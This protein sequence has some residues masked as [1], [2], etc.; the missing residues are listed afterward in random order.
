MLSPRHLDPA[1]SSGAR[2]QEAVSPDRTGVRGPARRRRRRLLR[3]RRERRANASARSAESKS[4]ARPPGDHGWRLAGRTQALLERLDALSPEE[5]EAFFSRQIAISPAPDPAAL[6]LVGARAESGWRS[7]RLAPRLRTK[8]APCF[9]RWPGSP[10]ST[11]PSSPAGRAA[12]ARP[13]DPA[14]PAARPASRRSR[15]SSWRR[16]RNAAD[17]VGGDVFDAIELSPSTPGPDARR[18]LGARSSRGA[19]SARRRRGPADGRRPAPED[20]C[21]HRAAQPDPLH[22]DAGLAFR[23]ARLRRA[24][25]FGDL[26][27]R[28]RRPSGAASADPARSGARGL[29]AFGPGARRLSGLDLSGRRAEIPPERSAASLQRWGHGVSRRP[30]ARSSASRASRG[31]AQV[32]C[33]APATHV[34]SAIFEALGRARRRERLPD[35]ASVL[36][37]KRSVK[38]ISLSFATI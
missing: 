22:L 32:L 18:R 35:D 20:R 14:Q 7:F 29:S 24:R 4:R 12:R 34:V 31:I 2:A 8:A 3:R 5:R 23:L 9:S 11:A 1:V 21:D 27:L 15:V 17:V 38:L 16:A 6:W 28:Q 10:S 36:V 13:G 26:R 19:R 33:G 37:V 30:R 25:R